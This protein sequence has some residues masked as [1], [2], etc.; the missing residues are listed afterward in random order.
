MVEKPAERQPRI[1]I[2]LGL[3]DIGIGGDELMFGGGDIRTTTEKFCGQASR[4]DG[5][6]RGQG[7]GRDGELRGRPARQHRQSMLDIDAL[8]LDF[9]QL[10]RGRLDLRH[11]LQ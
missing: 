9:A 6:D 5:H 10:T 3:T 11:G 1:V 7:L 8:A 4:H 2:G